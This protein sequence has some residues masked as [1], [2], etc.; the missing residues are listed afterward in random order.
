MSHELDLTTGKAAMAYRGEVPW[1]GLGQTIPSGASVG[2]IRELAGLDWEARLTPAEF[3]APSSLGP[4]DVRCQV[5]DRKVLYRSD[6]RAPLGIV[7]D[8]YQ[9]LQPAEV[10]EFFRTL[11][12]DIGGFQIDTAGALFGGRKIWALAQVGDTRHVSQG[13]AIAPYL[14]LATSYDGTMATVAEWTTV[15]VVCNNTLRLAVGAQGE[16]AAI[17]LSHRTTFDASALRGQLGIVGARFDQMMD[18]FRHLDAVPM[19]EEDFADYAESV[20]SPVDA[21]AFLEGRAFRKLLAQFK[22]Q[23]I[24]HGGKQTA[25][26]ALNAFTQ[27]TDHESGRLQDNRLQSAWFGQNADLKVR[28]FDILMEDYA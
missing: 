2:E 19:T 16:K 8:R 15:R 18:A 1:H 12:D 9:V 11:V 25:W 21:D 26:Q 17:R 6:T 13:D 27:Y 20:V 3:Q 14:L 23:G 5:P 4:W 24:G 10:F 28:A 7:S 22:G